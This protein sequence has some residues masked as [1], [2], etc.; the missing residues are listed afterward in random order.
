M[1]KINWIRSLDLEEL[2]ELLESIERKAIARG[3]AT[4]KQE[5]I[6]LLRGEKQ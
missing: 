1:R 3:R 4:S 6:Q 2:A 5:Y